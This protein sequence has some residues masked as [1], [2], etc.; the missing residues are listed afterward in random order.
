VGRKRRGGKRDKGT[1]EEKRIPELI[2]LPPYFPF[3]K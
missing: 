2:L 3:I 1:M